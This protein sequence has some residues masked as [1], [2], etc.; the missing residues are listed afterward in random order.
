VQRFDGR[1]IVEPVLFAPAKKPAAGPVIGLARVAVADRRR[2]KFKE[3]PR[4]AITGKRDD[5]RQHHIDT[6]DGHDRAG[7]VPDYDL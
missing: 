2:E 4:G 3:P 1:Q 5:R 6:G 7:R